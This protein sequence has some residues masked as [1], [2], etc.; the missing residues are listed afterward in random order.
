MNYSWQIGQLCLIANTYNIRAYL[1]VLACIWK[2]F[3][4]IIDNG[5]HGMVVL[6]EQ[7]LTDI[8]K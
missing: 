5:Y 4:A 3:H 1:R 6:P 7:T 8:R 2:Y